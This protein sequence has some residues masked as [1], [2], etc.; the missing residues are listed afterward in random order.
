MFIFY[1]FE[2]IFGYALDSFIGHSL[3]ALLLAVIIKSCSPGWIIEL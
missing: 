3:T 1:D 2:Y